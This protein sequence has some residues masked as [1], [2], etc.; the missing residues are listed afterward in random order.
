[1]KEFQ[2]NEHLTLKLER[3]DKTYI[4]VNEELFMGCKYVLLNLPVDDTQL[5]NDINSIDEAEEKLDKSLEL[6][7][8]NQDI[9][10]DPETEFWAHC[11]N[12]Q[13]WAEHSYDTRLLHRKLSFPLLSRLAKA[14]DQLAVMALKEEIAERLSSGNENVAEFL[15]NEGYIDYLSHEEQI[16]SVLNPVEAEALLE[17]EQFTGVPFIQAGSWMYFDP[18]TFIEPTHQ[19]LVRNKSVIALLIYWF[20]KPAKILP[21]SIGNFKNIEVLRYIGENIIELPKSI[22]KLKNL[23]ELSVDSEVLVKFPNSVIRLENL[24]SLIIRSPLLCSIPKKISNLK[25]LKQLSVG[26][27]IDNIPDSLSQLKNLES[28][29]LNNNPLKKIP[30]SIYSLENLFQFHIGNTNI[31]EL[32]E[33]IAMLKNLDVLDIKQ[34]YIKEIP[35]AVLSLEKLRILFVKKNNLSEKSIR[36]IDTLEKRGVMIT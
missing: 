8:T 21:E 10:I 28:L 34:I 13:A 23:R 2:I 29:N 11:S 24:E 18:G 30:E 26:S 25:R 16:V 3:D 1:M 32:S 6:L 15:I 14:G 35:E 7:D 12:L 19:F 36:I 5:L 33:S 20:D 31:K 4:F 27:R 17:L 22:Y 9:Y